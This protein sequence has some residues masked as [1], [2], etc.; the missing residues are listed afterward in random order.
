MIHFSKLGR[1]EYVNHSINSD[2]FWSIKYVK[3][4]EY[5]VMYGKNGYGAQQ[6]LTVD[7]K[8]AAKRIKEKLAKGYDHID[9]DVDNFH[10]NEWIKNT[11]KH[12]DTILPEKGDAPVK[13]IKI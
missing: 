7:E 1:Y 5:E 3:P 12:Y 2:K 4:N 9:T 11:K 10:K 13:K 6:T 8:V